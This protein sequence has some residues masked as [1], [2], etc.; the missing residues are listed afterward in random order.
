[1]LSKMVRFHSF[2]GQ[3]IVHCTSAPFLYPV[4]Y[5][6]TL[7]LLPYLGKWVCVQA[8]YMGALVSARVPSH[9]DGRNPCWFSHSVQW[10]LL[11]PALELELHAPQGRP[12]QPRHRSWFSAT[13]CGCGTSSSCL[14]TTWRDFFPQDFCS[15]RGSSQWH[16]WRLY[17]LVVVLDFYP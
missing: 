12:W 11:F 10:G 4:I 5:L 8:L 17:S 13:T 7:R 3:V 1:M 14:S 15:P 6:W 9:L 16:R 2:Y